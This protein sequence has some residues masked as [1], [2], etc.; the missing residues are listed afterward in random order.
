MTDPSPRPADERSSFGVVLLIG[1]AVA[2][3]AV[4]AVGVLQGSSG[5]WPVDVAWKA[6]LAE[7]GLGPVL[8]ER[9]ELAGQAYRQIYFEL[10][11]YRGL[12]AVGVGA[13]L[14][15]AGALLQ[16]VFRNDLAAPGVIGVSAGASLGAAL[17]ILGLGGYAG[18]LVLETAAGFG[19]LAV[20]GAAFVGAMASVS[21][22]ALFAS[23]RGP[24]SVPTLLL[25]GVAVNATW[26]GLLTLVQSLVLDDYDTGR[27]L[28]AW[29]FGTLEDRLG[30]QVAVLW[31]GLAVAALIGP[32]VAYELDLFQ[33]GEED[34]ASLG[35]DV[36]RVKWLTLA[37]ASLAAATAVSVAGQIGF[38]GL[39]APHV[40]RQFVGRSHRLLLPASALG[41]ALML[42]G[43]D[44]AQRSLVTGQQLPPGVMTS[45]V[46]GPFFFFLL[47]R[48]RREVATW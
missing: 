25:L 12:T 1:L 42:A 26:G 34:A 20:S 40:M 24:L 14:A 36:R 16:G 38:V 33:T 46:G 48:N 8:E 13:A 45:L 21:I 15:Y 6:T 23:S 19:P 43:L 27:A 37:A 4:V 35:V 29:T 7:L 11:L 41:G 9:P 18:Q 47:W 39:V 44:L 30:I 22:V 32:F 10:R 28:L 31:G 5:W 2:L 3:V 17:V